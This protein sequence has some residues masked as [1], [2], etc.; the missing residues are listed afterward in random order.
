MKNRKGGVPTKALPQ[1]TKAL[2]SQQ[3]TT[4]AN[5]GLMEPVTVTLT[6]NLAAACRFFA[7]VMEKTPERLVID[8]TV[9]GLSLQM[10]DSVFPQQDDIEEWLLENAGK[11]GARH[12]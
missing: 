12:A 3:I 8:E 11:E 7:L 2:R 1:T 5:S 10:I 9:H 6:G 4:A